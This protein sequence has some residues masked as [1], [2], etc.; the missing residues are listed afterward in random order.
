M[1]MSE[2]I[3]LERFLELEGQVI[4]PV[5]E[6]ARSGYKYWRAAH[7][8]AIA[9]NFIKGRQ[10]LNNAWR[11]PYTHFWDKYEQAVVTATEL[12]TPNSFRKSQFGDEHRRRFNNLVGV[13]SN[14]AYPSIVLALDNRLN[15]QVEELRVTDPFESSIEDLFDVKTWQQP[16]SPGGGVILR[17][18]LTLDKIDSHSR[19]AIQDIFGLKN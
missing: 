10:H 6:E 5:P 11:A 1:V 17:G 8:G 15:E 18:E 2:R 19:V 16:F 13:T 3:N 4:E 7:L 12:S 9:L 14:F